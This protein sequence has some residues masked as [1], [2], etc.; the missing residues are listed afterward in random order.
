MDTACGTSQVG[1]WCRTKSR[2]AK[3]L[4]QLLITECISA[5]TRTVASNIS[6]SGKL[7]FSW[8]RQLTDAVRPIAV[9]QQAHKHTHR[10]PPSSWLCTSLRCTATVKSRPDKQSERTSKRHVGNV[11]VALEGYDVYG[12]SKIRSD[13]DT[14]QHEGSWCHTGLDRSHRWLTRVG[15][16]SFPSL[17][18]SWKERLLLR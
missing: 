13:K 12:R 15:W 16:S 7:S 1:S 10:K 2:N 11:L 6:G 18:I 14:P 17:V 8:E 5:E 4:P 3:M 9:L